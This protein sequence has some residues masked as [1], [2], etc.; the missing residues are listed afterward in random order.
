MPGL[1]S[2]VGSNGK[3]WYVFKRTTEAISNAYRE[4]QG[5]ITNLSLSRYLAY[6]RTNRGITVWEKEGTERGGGP[7]PVEGLTGNVCPNH[8]RTTKTRGCHDPLVT[9]SILSKTRSFSS[10]CAAPTRQCSSTLVFPSL[11]CPIIVSRERKPCSTLRKIVFT[12]LNEGVYN[13]CNLVG[14]LRAC[15]RPPWI[16]PINC[17]NL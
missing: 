3:Q 17:I 16:L 10:M 14:Q 15:Y 2:P 5:A 4:T 13:L 6:A 11:P 12:Y 1:H 7:G 8:G 9:C